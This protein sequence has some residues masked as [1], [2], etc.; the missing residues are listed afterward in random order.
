MPAL[1]ICLIPAQL[2]MAAGLLYAARRSMEPIKQ[3]LGFLPQMGRVVRRLKLVTLAAVTF[4]AS[5]VFL[6]LSHLLTP[7]LRRKT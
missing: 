1:L 4:S 5:L 2:G 7:P 6:V 3:R